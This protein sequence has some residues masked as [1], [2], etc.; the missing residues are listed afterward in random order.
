VLEETIELPEAMAMSSCHG[1]AWDGSGF[2]LSDSQLLAKIDPQG[3][4]VD[5]YAYNDLE[6]PFQEFDAL[7]WDGTD[8]WAIEDPAQED[9]SRSRIWR[10][11]TSSGEPLRSIPSPPDGS[12]PSLSPF[13]LGLAWNGTD[14][15]CLRNGESQVVYRI[16]RTDG[17]VVD[18]FAVADAVDEDPGGPL[19][20]PGG[21]GAAGSDLCYADRLGYVYRLR[22]GDG[23]IL[24]RFTTSDWTMGRGPGGIAWDGTLL[25]V[26]EGE[27]KLRGYSMPTGLVP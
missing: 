10:I 19:G 20:M 27:G 11:D 4:L 18:S 23:L 8:L 6:W 3:H 13:G 1:I 21:F 25:W 14:M 2:W 15:Y 7:C 12:S 24:R 16:D 9:Y 26:R 5:S 17:S 22:S